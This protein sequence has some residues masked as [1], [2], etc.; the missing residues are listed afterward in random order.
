MLD[1][2]LQR[3]EPHELRYVE[4]TVNPGNAA[5]R[6]LFERLATQQGSVLEEEIFLEASDFGPG[7]DHEC[8]IL[9]RVPL[10]TPNS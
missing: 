2:L 6:R 10:S 3:F 4:A 7:G 8:E 1:E 9:L 5:S